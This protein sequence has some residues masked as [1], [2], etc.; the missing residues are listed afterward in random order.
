VTARAN[1][2][3]DYELEREF[4]DYTSSGMPWSGFGAKAY[5]CREFSVRELHRRLSDGSIESYIKDP[6]SG[7]LMRISQTAWQNHPFWYD[8]IRGRLIH[9]SARD[10]MQEFNGRSVFLKRSAVEKHLTGAVRR[11]PASQ[12][13]AC[14]AWLEKLLRATPGARP[15]PKGQLRE[16]AMVRFRVTWREFDKCWIIAH[17]AVPE[18]TWRHPGAPKKS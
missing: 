17:Q 13:A 2:T 16:E 18:A 5:M 8:T 14:Q 3:S 15:R 12:I 7:E 1:N 4:G 9:A 6:N 11:K 10:G